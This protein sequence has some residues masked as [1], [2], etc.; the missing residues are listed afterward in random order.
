[1]LLLD[2]VGPKTQP[3]VGPIRL[4]GG[5]VGVVAVGSP[6]AP[7]V[8]RTLDAVADDGAA[9]PD[10]RTEVLAVPFEHVQLAGLVAIDH[11]VLAEVSQRPDVTDGVLRRPADHEP[12][13]DFPSEWNLHAEPPRTG[14]PTRSP[15][16]TTSPN[17][18]M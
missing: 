9:M 14:V 15:A 1:M 13:G 3:L 8:E 16:M 4:V 12:A 7:A 6:P 18:S 10:V 11:Q 2:R 17:A 5:D